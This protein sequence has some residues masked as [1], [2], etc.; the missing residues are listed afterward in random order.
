MHTTYHTAPLDETIGKS[1][2]QTMIL[3][4]L[5]ACDTSLSLP[6][7]IINIILARAVLVVSEDVNCPITCQKSN[8]NCN[9][10]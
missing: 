6:S 4:L 8:T 1:T 7:V 3:T 5:T 9:H 2:Q 10:L